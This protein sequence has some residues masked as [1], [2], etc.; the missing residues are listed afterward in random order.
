MSKAK[1]VTVQAKIGG[2]LVFDKTIE[3]KCRQHALLTEC[4]VHVNDPIL[5]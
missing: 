5:T 4:M 1:Q 3:G 2:Q